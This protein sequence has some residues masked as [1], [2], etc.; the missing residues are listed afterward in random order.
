MDGNSRA[1]ERKP[2]VVVTGSSGLIGS[3]L[4]R[5]LER[6]YD[7]V[8]LDIVE[9]DE[10][11]RA[12]EWIHC[13]FTSDQSVKEALD[14]VRANHGERLASVVHLAAY[15]DFSGQPSELYEELTVRGTERLL[16]ALRSFRVEQIVF[17]STFLA[18]RLTELG[19][20]RRED[21][22]DEAEW[23]YPASKLRAEDVIRRERGNI[24]TVLL[25][26][27]GVYAENGHSPPITPHVRR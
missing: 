24:P 3:A 11:S 7:V 27:A 26:I 18:I 17:S 1:S 13:D 22:P 9:P 15:Y 5:D 21:S 10:D 6:F 14:R 2:V 19:R 4:C 8:G 12:G 20:P 23:D 16:R 25:R